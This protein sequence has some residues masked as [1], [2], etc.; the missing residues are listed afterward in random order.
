MGEGVW[1]FGSREKGV[2]GEGEKMGF[3]P[4]ESERKRRNGVQGVL[5]VK[6]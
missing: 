1:G 3:V 6:C 2:L 5:E 4:F